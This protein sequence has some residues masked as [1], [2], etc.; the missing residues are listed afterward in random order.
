MI[1]AAYK[2]LVRKYHPDVSASPNATELMQ[3]LNR[4]Y[5]VLRDP[6]ERAAYDQRRRGRQAERQRTEPPRHTQYSRT[7]RSQR[8]DQRQHAHG[9]VRPE[10]HARQ[11]GDH[12]GRRPASDTRKSSRIS[13]WSGILFLVALLA[14]SGSDAIQNVVHEAWSWATRSSPGKAPA[15]SPAVPDPASPNWWD[16]PLLP[17]QPSSRPQRMVPPPTAQNGLA[18]PQRAAATRPRPTASRP[19]RV[20]AHPDV[21]ASSRRPAGPSRTPDVGVLSASE[22]AAIERMCGH[23]GPVQG[24]AAY[25]R[26]VEEAKRNRPDFSGLGRRRAQG[27]R[28]HVRARGASPRTRRLRPL[29]RRGEAELD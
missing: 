11:Q 19:T 13:Q 7:E 3:R 18:E 17:R 26:C 21:T 2:R 27:H 29:R 8:T 5:E 6:R 10:Q 1:E 4:A 14:L 25:A 16:Q 23:V 22:L 15:S 28:A 9:R 24:P 12:W 20:A